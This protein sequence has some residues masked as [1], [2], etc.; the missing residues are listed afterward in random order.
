MKIEALGI[1]A[2]VW[3]N[4]VDYDTQMGVVSR[5][6]RFDEDPDIMHILG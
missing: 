3:W 2:A 1:K 5:E 6:Y 4:H